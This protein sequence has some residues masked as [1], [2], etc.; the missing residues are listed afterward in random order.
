[1]LAESARILSV[2]DSAT[3]ARIVIPSEPLAVRDGL[4]ALFETLLLRALP[5]AARGTAEIVLAEAM[6]NIVEHA[7]SRHSGLIEVTLH[8]QQPDLLCQIEDQGLPMPGEVLPIGELRAFAGTEDLPEGGFGWHLIRALSRDLHY[9]RV[10]GRN[11]LSF[12]LETGQ[13]AP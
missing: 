6:N 2:S 11:Y 12:R 8:L 1:M 5:E 7:Y 13:S 9:H 3:E 10:D 4:R